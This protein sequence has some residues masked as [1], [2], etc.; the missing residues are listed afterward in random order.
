MLNMFV[1]ILP[2]SK[3]QNRISFKDCN[4]NRFSL[5]EIE[6]FARIL[7]KNYSLNGSLAPL[8]RR[9]GGDFWESL[10]LWVM[11]AKVIE[12]V[13]ENSW[14]L[15]PVYGLLKPDACIPYAPIDW[16][17]VYEGKNLFDFWKIHLKNL[18]K[19]LLKDKVVIPF[20]PKKYL[21]LFNLSYAKEI[22]FFEYHRGEKEIRNP[23]KHFAYTLR[24]IVEKGLD[25]EEFSKIN[26]YDYQVFERLKKD[27]HLYIKLRSGGKY[28]L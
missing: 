24:Y 1:F 4:E 2:Y 25:I 12:Y 16:K 7:E 11:P 3:K 26:F 8:Y 20:V 23:E 22:V 10:E 15:S 28:E 9:L 18:S 27:N 13:K 6:P 17:E 21:S 14:V 19:I 5:K